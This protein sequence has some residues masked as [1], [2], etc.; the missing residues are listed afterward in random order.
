MSWDAYVDQMEAAHVTYA[1][2]F[3]RSGGLWAQSKS[4]ANFAASNEEAM[5]AEQII[6]SRN[7]DACANGFTVR[8]VALC[9]IVGFFLSCLLIVTRDVKFGIQI[10]SGWP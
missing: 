9:L 10:G 8:V 7:Q 5:L 6:A 2:I 4:A 1:A 3:G